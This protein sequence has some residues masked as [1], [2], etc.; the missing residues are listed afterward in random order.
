MPPL[1]KWN[2]DNNLPE[3]DNFF[4]DDW[5]PMMRMP[6]VITPAIDVYE[7]KDQ[8]VVEA[9]ISGI[10]P[11]DVNIEI[12]DNILKISGQSEHQSEVDDKNYYRKEIRS[13]AFYRAVALP[14]AVK[15]DQA[16]ATY[17]DGILKIT[18]PKADEA[19]PRRI[20]IKAE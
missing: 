18:I 5:F 4:A 13:G 16:Q 8:V 15:S 17:K 9:P 19:K 1:I 10:K 2:P 14:K 12:E 20:S 11:A 7:N 6:R 3:I